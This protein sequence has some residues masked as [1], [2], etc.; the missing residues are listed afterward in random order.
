[1][2]YKWLK[3]K[4]K[5]LLPFLRAVVRT[6]CVDCQRGTVSRTRLF[7]KQSMQYMAMVAARCL[8]QSDATA[9]N[10]CVWTRGIKEKRKHKN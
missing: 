6:G 10:P 5:T 9:L 3:V 7:A 4:N 8:F 2:K 1:M